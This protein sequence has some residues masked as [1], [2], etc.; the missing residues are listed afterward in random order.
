MLT[1]RKQNF[2]KLRKNLFS[3][4]KRRLTNINK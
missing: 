3:I 1:L 4:Q 2:Q